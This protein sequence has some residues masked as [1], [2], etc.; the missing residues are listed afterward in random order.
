MVK[1]KVD[2]REMRSI[3]PKSDRKRHLP[4]VIGVS[5]EASC[6]VVSDKS[7]IVVRFPW[8]FS[9]SKLVKEPSSSDAIIDGADE[10]NSNLAAELNK[11]TQKIEEVYTL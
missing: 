2:N 3:V 9:G 6:C 10:V 8:D 7:C 5:F 4:T 11:R 1:L